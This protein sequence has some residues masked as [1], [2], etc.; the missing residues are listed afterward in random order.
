MKELE[1]LQEEKVKLSMYN[2]YHQ[3]ALGERFNEQEESEIHQCSDS[4][5]TQSIKG[6]SSDG[7]RGEGVC[8]QVPQKNSSATT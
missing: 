3:Q 7:S 8:S 6:A 1:I 2:Y 4:K 5:E